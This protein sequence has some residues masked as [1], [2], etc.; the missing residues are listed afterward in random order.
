MNLKDKTV[1]GE[2]NGL[3]VDLENQVKILEKA[4]WYFTEM[5]Y[6]TPVKEPKKQ[7][8]PKE[9]EKP[10]KKRKPKIPTFAKKPFQ[11]GGIKAIKANL[12]VMELMKERY[13]I[14]QL[15]T[16]KTNQDYVE[17]KFGTYRAMAGSCTNPTAFVFLQIVSR[18]LLSILLAVAA[19][20]E[21]SL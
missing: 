20:Q 12:A 13:N 14:P 11:R 15:T 1:N 10:K 4:L 21:T 6:K 5:R 7:K 16:S 9:G 2:L 3:G 18:D 17:N 8:E 19:I